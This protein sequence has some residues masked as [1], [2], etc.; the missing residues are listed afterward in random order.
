MMGSV[1]NK[2]LI[3]LTVDKNSCSRCISHEITTV[4]YTINL[5]SCNT[6]IGDIDSHIPYFD[7]L[8]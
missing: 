7:V 1:N 4:W 6:P 2:A 5:I 3:W 8:V